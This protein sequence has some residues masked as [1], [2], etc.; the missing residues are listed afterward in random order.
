DGHEL[1]AMLFR[2]SATVPGVDCWVRPTLFGGL[3]NDGVSEEESPSSHKD[4]SLHA[5]D[6]ELGFARRSSVEALA[7]EVRALRE[8]QGDIKAL[9]QEVVARLPPPQAQES[10]PKRRGSALT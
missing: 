5:A 1:P 10:T 9:L 2:K 4:S 7:G 8:E 6:H 3:H